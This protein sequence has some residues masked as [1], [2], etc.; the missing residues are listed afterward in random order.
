MQ[1]S[2]PVPGNKCHTPLEINS[3][4][5][6]G[7]E[8]GAQ[9]FYYWLLDAHRYILSCAQLTAIDHRFRQLYKIVLDLGYDLG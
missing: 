6:L 4:T 8:N 7:Y 3:K 5:C 2:L 1:S 9:G